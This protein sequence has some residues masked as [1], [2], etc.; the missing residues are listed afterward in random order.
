M[1]KGRISKRKLEELDYLLSDRDKAILCSLQSCR[2]LTSQQVRRWHFLE[3]SSEPA[4]M[5]AANRGLV[6]LQGYGLIAALKRRLGGTQAGSGANVWFLTEAGHRLLHLRDTSYTPR[7]RRFT[8]SPVFLE[9]TV[10]VAEAYL[11]IQE[12]C[13]RNRW[14]AVKLEPEPVCWRGYTD[15]DGKPSTLKPDLYA[16]IG[17]GEFEDSWFFE[18]DLDTE[19]PCIILEK[20]KRYDHY[21]RSGIEQRES[22]VFPLVVWIMSSTARKKNLRQHIADCREL[23]SKNIFLVI[24]PD[25]LEALLR[26][27]GDIQGAPAFDGA[28]AQEPPTIDNTKLPQKRRTQ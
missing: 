26:G 13:R 8:P 4:A 7:K 15:G 28:K 25:E 21:Y 3:H 17:N 23:Q 12:S 9:H 22:G 6:K 27:G 10:A 5:R 1:S 19:S 24:L 11:Q 2:Y 16:V 14:E 20:C 18:I